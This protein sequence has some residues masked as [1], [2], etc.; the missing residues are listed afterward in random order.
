MGSSIWADS[1]NLNEISH[2]QSHKIWSQIESSLDTVV[3]NWEE[4]ALEAGLK[5][6]DAKQI[7]NVLPTSS[8]NGSLKLLCRKGSGLNFFGTSPKSF[9]LITIFYFVGKGTAFLLCR[10]NSWIWPNKNFIQRQMFYFS[11]FDLQKSF[12]SKRQVLHCWHS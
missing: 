10:H 7:V 9:V 6:I 5:L 4:H 2:V 12:K 8:P 11:I 1:H 3:E